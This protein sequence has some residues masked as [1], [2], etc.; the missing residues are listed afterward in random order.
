MTRTF[1]GGDAMEAMAAFPHESRALSS[2]AHVRVAA[3]AN[4]GPSFVPGRAGG[5]NLEP[6]SAEIAF[7]PAPRG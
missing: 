1:R 2:I 3:A 7:L 5:E 6:A 4:P